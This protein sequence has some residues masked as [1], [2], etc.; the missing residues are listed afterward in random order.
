MQTWKSR[1][2]SIS[3]F[4]GPF[5]PHGLDIYSPKGLPDGFYLH[6]VNHK[7]ASHGPHKANSTV[8]IFRISI[9]DSSAT[10][11]QTVHHPLIVTPND[12]YSLSATEFLVT[13]DHVNREPGL[14]RTAEE[15]FTLQLTSRTTVV[16]VDA[17]SGIKAEVVKKGIHSAN[18]LAHGPGGEIALGS[19]AG[20][21]LHILSPDL[22][23]TSTVSFPSTLDNPTY[24]ADP[25]ATPSSDL[26]GYVLA[27]LLQAHKLG[28]HSADPESLAPGAIWLARK[29][30][31]G[32]WE[33]KLLLEDDGAWVN[34]ATTAML[35]PIDPKGTNGRREAWVVAVGFMA[36]GISVARVDLTE[37][38]T[39]T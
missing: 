25:Y 8:E 31:A 27:G 1:R 14:L 22:T 33:K 7:P 3:G 39:R 12:I 17:S 20:G 18:G 30:A 24:L 10:H 32:K 2:L 19:A 21:V 9:S 36:R 38:A 37:W 23:T 6:A 5:I 13:N 35:L 16:K 29:T 15:V 4:T 28:E 11:L 34:A 26:S